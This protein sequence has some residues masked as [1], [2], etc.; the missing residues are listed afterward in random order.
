MHDSVGLVSRWSLNVNRLILRA[1]DGFSYER[2]TSTGRAAHPNESIRTK[3]LENL[4]NF[5]IDLFMIEE[6]GHRVL[7]LTTETFATH[8]RRSDD[9]CI[10]AAVADAVSVIR[11]HGLPRAPCR[12][13]AQCGAVERMAIAGGWQHLSMTS[14]G[15][16]AEPSLFVHTGAWRRSA[17]R[18]LGSARLTGLEE[19]VDLVLNH[20]AI[21]NVC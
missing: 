11:C 16:Q 6:I 2:P 18:V 17:L 1:S 5:R 8:L 7:I 9:N 21:H 3:M 10:S 19:C 14:L 12:A 13:Q 15:A 20:D 4:G